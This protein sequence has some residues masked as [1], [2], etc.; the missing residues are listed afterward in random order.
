MHA[1]CN[2]SVNGELFSAARGDVLLEAALRN[3]IDIPHDCR[4]GKCGTCRVRVMDGKV[5]GVPDGEPNVMRACRCRITANVAVA[6]EEMPQLS[7]CSGVVRELNWRSQDIVE[8]CIEPSRRL[9]HPPGQFLHVQFRDFPVRPYSPAVAFE[10][11]DDGRF[12]R[13]HVRQHSH[14]QSSSTLGRQI[15]VGHRARLTGPFGTA[16]L[17]GRLSNR[18]VLVSGGTGFAPIWA[19]VD[20][21]LRE[22]ASR[23]TVAIAGARSLAALRMLPALCELATGVDVKLLA[24][25]GGHWRIKCRGER[26]ACR[27]S[28]AVQDD[29][30][31][32]AGTPEV[33]EGV[34]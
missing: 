8:V 19:I 11:P 4:S 23:T 24:V 16:Y 18:L 21:A 6:F 31:H 29:I 30:V 13:F 15:S 17:R 9:R 34:L 7:A 10:L 5:E 26:A 32:V 14:G 33:V 22:K 20:A 2:V 25:T 12:I 28:P 1:L 27:L 3:G